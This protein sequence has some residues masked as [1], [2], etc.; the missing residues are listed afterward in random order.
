MTR[1]TPITPS[2]DFR[3]L[4]ESAPGL[5]LVLTPSLVIVAVSDAY[6]NGTMTKRD[7]ILGRHLFDVFP[8][9]PDDPTATGVANLR[10]SLDRVLQHRKSDSMAVQ[11]YDIRRPDSEGRG[12]EERH[13]SPVNSPV[14][15][16][17]GEVAYLIHRVEDVTEFVRLK[18]AKSEQQRITEDLRT[19]TVEMEA[20]IFRRAQQIQETNRQLR[21]ELDARKRMEAKFQGLLEAAPDAM[22]IVDRDGR[23][24]LINAQTERLFGYGRKELLGQLVEVLIPPRFRPQHP[25]H[26]TGYFADPRSRP[27]GQGLELYGLRKDGS[28]FPIDISLSPIQTE[29]GPLVTAA[30]RDV[31]ERKRAEEAQRKLAAIVESSDDAIISKDLDGTIRSWNKGAERLF[32]YS[33]EETIGCP[34]T[35]LISPKDQEEESKILDRIRG[36]ENIKH[37]E[38]IWVKKDGT[39]LDVSLA[40]SPIKDAAG[41]I[42]GISKTARDITERKRAEEERDRFF[43]LS[44]DMLCIA[45]S[46]GYFKR[47]SPAFTKTL[48]WNAEEMLTRPFL[49]FVHPDDHAATL[50]EVE[51]QV[52]AGEQVLQFENRYR[53]KDGSW[54]VLS[55][56]SIPQPDG[57]MYAIARDVTEQKQAEETLARQVRSLAE[58][59]TELERFN[60]AAVGR[61]LKMIELKRQINEMFQAAGKPPA[62]DL[63]T[64]EK[65]Q[66]L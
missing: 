18:Q 10:A 16:P 43:S 56:K 21:A 32:G 55:W 33:P 49:D 47:V 4:F 42:V 62:Y 13:W 15:G 64:I 29:E 39:R 3:T 58:A 5:Y 19:R 27:M 26:R 63:S 28:E 20:E 34:L 52:V 57:F 23:I 53:H 36:G 41:T 50:R 44:L 66:L 24:Q 59:N 25:G 40:V 2:P 8:D 17:K 61:E 9:N 48:G 60:R 7:E 30:I 12:F 37:Y 51:R 38:T 11:K 14:L 31:T 1:S 45:R 46:D 35:M 54:R 65:E 22:V 6:L